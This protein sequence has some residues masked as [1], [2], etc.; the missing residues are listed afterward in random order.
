MQ[1]LSF[2]DLGKPAVLAVDVVDL[3]RSTGLSVPKG[4]L[5]LK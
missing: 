5:N 2:I 1:I 3:R 4:H